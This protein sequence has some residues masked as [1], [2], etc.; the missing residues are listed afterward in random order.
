M[1]MQRFTIF[2]GLL[3]LTLVASAAMADPL[4]PAS[5]RLTDET[6]RYPHNVLGGIPGRATL[7]VTL[8]NGTQLRHTLPDARV[9][10]DIAPRLWDIDADG[11]PEIVTVESDQSHGARL[12]A[13]AIENTG[14][15]PRLHLRTAGEFI[16]RRFR[17][18]AP[19][20]I[21]DFLGTGAPQIAYVAM[22]H[23]ARQLVIV[24][25]EGARF[26]P[27]RTLDGVSNH[28]IG[29]EVITS[30]TR[31]CGTTTEI[32]VPSGDWRRILGI[33]FSSGQPVIR[34]LGRYRAQTGLEGLPPCAE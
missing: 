12:T 8:E 1:D 32:V 2:P 13:W 34:D 26:V 20:G 9:F 11:T 31:L 3:A 18:L 27:V 14:E 24:A 30:T 10:E 29:D 28:R 5:A 23:L 19:L 33:R 6:D 21:A 17:W 16:G 4:A 15:G 25:V 7:E 22:P